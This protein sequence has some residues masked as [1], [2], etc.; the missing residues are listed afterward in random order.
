MRYGANRG[1]GAAAPRFVGG[2]VGERGLGDLDDFGVQ[3]LAFGIDLDR[4]R[5]RRRAGL[6]DGCVEAEEV[7]HEH[8]LF[9]L[10][11][12]DRDGGHAA[13]GAARGG[14][15]PGDVDL[16]HDPA[17]EDV[18]VDIRG[19]GHRHDAQYRVAI[20]RQSRKRGFGA[21]GHA[22]DSKAR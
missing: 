16:S 10:E 7:A 12:I 14:D 18:P 13:G 1:E 5:D 15:R 21:G 8:G 9:E 11:G 2:D 4:H 6:G 20:G 3:A 22:A 17:A 19:S